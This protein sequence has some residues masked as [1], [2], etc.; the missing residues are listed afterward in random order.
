[1]E[2]LNCIEKIICKILK[3]GA[4]PNHIGFIMDGNRR[5][6][7]NRKLKSS[8]EGHVEG[9]KSLK[10]CLLICG[11]LGV[12][13]VSLFCFSIENFNRNQEEVNR[14]MELCIETFHQMSNMSEILLKS[15]AKVNIIGRR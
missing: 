2:S 4:V 9:V 11:E 10:K 1:M 3:A 12:K 13:E 7:K 8:H 5:Y 14:L 6:A 15:E